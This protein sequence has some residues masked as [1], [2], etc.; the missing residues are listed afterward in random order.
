MCCR[1]E[2]VKI[3]LPGAEGGFGKTSQG[4]EK[5]KRE[6]EKRLRGEK[7]YL[8]KYSSREK[9]KRRES[10]REMAWWWT[11][12]RPD[13]LRSLHLSLSIEIGLKLSFKKTN[14]IHFF[15]PIFQS[16]PTI[17]HRGRTFHGVNFH[18]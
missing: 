5:E 1:K 15:R 16:P 4:E 12:T 11:K 9:C 17:T 8:G 3:S 14:S 6:K 2:V 10:E 7:G 18:F 13:K